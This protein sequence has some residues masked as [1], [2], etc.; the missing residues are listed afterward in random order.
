VISP[1][2]ANVYL[3]E[4]LDTWFEQTVRPRLSGRTCL[5][6]Y[7]DDAVMVFEKEDDARRALEV[8]PKRFGKYGLTLHPEK[9]RLVAFRQPRKDEADD[10]TTPRPGTFDLLGFTHYW[11]LSR[12]GHGV[13][14]RKTATGRLNDALRRIAQWC[15][16]NRHRPIVEQWKILSS[17]LRGHYGYYGITGNMRSIELFL[18]ATERL[19]RK[20]LDRRSNHARMN[21]VRFGALLLRIPLPPARL[22]C[23]I[24]RVAN[25]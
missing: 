18:H 5:I 11:G 25:P 12:K 22:P 10:R 15:R 21:W 13:V 8:L 20:W 14:K 4:V 9:T 1:L 19:W 6:R 7:A 23:S 2:L 3:H 24:Y 16:S 17:K